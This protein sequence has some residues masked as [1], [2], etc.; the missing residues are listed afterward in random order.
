LLILELSRE[1]SSEER[2]LFYIVGGLLCQ[3]PQRGRLEFR[4]VSDGSYLLVAIHDYKPSLPWFIYILTQAKAHLL[5]MYLF[6]KHL[7][8]LAEIQGPPA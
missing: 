3:T 8:E 2:S 4:E 1:R 5:V 7:K 6:G